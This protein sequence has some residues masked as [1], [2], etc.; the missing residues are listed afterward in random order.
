M[1]K[2]ASR[3]LQRKGYGVGRERFKYSKLP[4]KDLES[5][6]ADKFVAA[7]IARIKDPRHHSKLGGWPLERFGLIG[8]KL[9]YRCNRC[10]YQSPPELADDFARDRGNLKPATQLLKVRRALRCGRCRAGCPSIV[11]HMGRSI[12]TFGGQ[13]AAL[14]RNVPTR[15]DQRV[16]RRRK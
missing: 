11:I 15:G 12:F 3:N 14:V 13:R 5:E 7:E 10:G 8:L 1:Y 4:L 9:S 2:T 6:D 16:G